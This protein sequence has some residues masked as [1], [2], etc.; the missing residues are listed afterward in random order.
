[1]VNIALGSA[2]GS[3][4]PAGVATGDGSITINELI[5]AVSNALYGCAMR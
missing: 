5:G 3:A 1:M 4:C 2:D